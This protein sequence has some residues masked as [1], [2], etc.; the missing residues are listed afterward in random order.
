[1]DEY[2]EFNIE[3]KVIYHNLPGIYKPLQEIDPFTH[4]L[5]IILS[6]QQGTHLSISNYDD[7]DGN[8]PQNILKVPKSHSFEGD[9]RL[10][11]PFA[12]YHRRRIKSFYDRIIHFCRGRDYQVHI[13]PRGYI[14]LSGIEDVVKEGDNRITIE[15]PEST[16]N[17]SGND[18]LEID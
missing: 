15:T 2:S 13:F 11:M 12:V 3:G 8:T 16:N 9:S 7:P 4:K 10:D 14:H 1:M 6:L 17:G 18:G 5:R